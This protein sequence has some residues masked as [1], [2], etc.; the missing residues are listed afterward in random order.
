MRLSDLPILGEFQVVLCVGLG[1][2]SGSWFG[3]TLVSFGVLQQLYVMASSQ[4]L[5]RSKDFRNS[6]AFKHQIFLAASHS[7]LP[8]ILA[9][10]LPSFEFEASGFPCGVQA[11]QKHSQDPM[12]WHFFPFSTL[13]GLHCSFVVQK[14]V[15]GRYQYHEPRYPAF[16]NRDLYRGSRPLM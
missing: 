5:L 3:L 7:K 14:V 11:S 9:S 2:K 10:N 16:A 1:L 8:S 4:A 13:V 15:A 6:K 12:S